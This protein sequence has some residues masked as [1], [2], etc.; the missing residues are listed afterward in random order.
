[1]LPAI[2]VPQLLVQNRQGVWIVVRRRRAVGAS[3]GTRG[4]IPGAGHLIL[5]ARDCVRQNFHRVV[6]TPLIFVQQRLVVENFQTAGGELL[7]AQQARLGL[8]EFSEPP[9]ELRDPQ[10]I[11]GCAGFHFR[12]LL[13]LLERLGVFV[14]L[15][16]RLRQPMQMARIIGIFFHGFPVR[17]FRFSVI[18]RL[19]VRITQQVVDFRR[20]RGSGSVRKNLHS[21]LRAPFVNQKLA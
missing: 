15:H 4:A 10:I 1:M 12:K 7:G 18:F 13:E 11:F 20:R 21:L 6:V 16:Q 9:V 19:C 14:L 17:I 3:W 5:H 8:V 2:G